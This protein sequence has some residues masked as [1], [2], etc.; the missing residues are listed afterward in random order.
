M[1]QDE[2][3]HEMEAQ[4]SNLIDEGSKLDSTHWGGK[5]V[6]LTVDVVWR[7]LVEPERVGDGCEPV[8]CVCA[9]LKKCG[10]EPCVTAVGEALAKVTAD[11]QREVEWKAVEEPMK[12]RCVHFQRLC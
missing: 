8:W 11:A 10:R 6:V 1:E 2:G 5:P 12:V 3:S 9:P 4:D 7:W